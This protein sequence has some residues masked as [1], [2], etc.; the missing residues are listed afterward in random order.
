[1][2][3]FYEQFKK[4]LDN[5]PAPDFEEQD[6]TDMQQRLEQQATTPTKPI[7]YWT[8]AALALLLGM[9]GS[10][11]LVFSQLK[12]ANEKISQ[13]ETKIDTIVQ[14]TIIYRTDTVFQMV[15][16]EQLTISMQKERLSNLVKKQIEESLNKLSYENNIKK[17]TPRKQVST[18]RSTEKNTTFNL[19]DTQP[20]EKQIVNTTVDNSDLNDFSNNTR[21]EVLTTLKKEKIST[22]IF[23][24]LNISNND[25]QKTDLKVKE[26]QSTETTLLSSLSPSTSSIYFDKKRPLPAWFETPPIA[27]QRKKTFQQHIYPMRP[28]GIEMGATIGIGT[29]TTNNISHLDLNNFGALANIQFGQ[30][31]RLWVSATY[32][33]FKYESEKLGEQ[34]GIPIIVPPLDNLELEEAKVSRALWSVDTGLQYNFRTPKKWQPFI[35]LGL[36]FNSLVKN[37]VFYEFEEDNKGEHYKENRTLEN[38]KNLPYT[39]LKSGLSYQVIKKWRAQLEGNYMYQI[40]NNNNQLFHTLNGKFSILYDF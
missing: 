16:G 4:N 2:D 11:W 22:P 40:D 20:K 14:T 7:N 18:N 34:F 36:G 29:A 30:P 32:T 23:E 3:K 26:K 8:W 12:E 39:M 17:I 24:D 6:W 10:N 5:Q 21:R 13:L 33:S 35:G 37:K 15:D 31:W 27:I 1:M 19:S 9:I 25:F 38:A 28:R